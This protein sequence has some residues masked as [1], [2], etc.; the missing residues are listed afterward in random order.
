ML[1]FSKYVAAGND[2]VIMEDWSQ[3]LDLRSPQIVAL[4]DRRFG[5]GADG[6]LLLRPDPDADFRM[7][8]YNADGSRGEMCGNGARSL[9]HFARSRG[10]A[11]DQGRFQADDGFHQYS[12]GPE[13][14]RVEIIVTDALHDWDV[15]QTGC[16]FINTGVPHL[17][18]P[19]QGLQEFDL[20]SLGKQMNSHPAHPRGT[21]VNVVERLPQGLQVR[22]WER[23]VNTET[24]AC[25]TGAAAVSIFAHAKWE[26]PWPIE[27]D[28]KGGRLRVDHRGNQYWLGGPVGLVFTGRI[29]LS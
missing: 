27:L 21:N 10:K 8:Y 18:V 28:F 3:T 5:V 15:P 17:I 9:V 4:C 16:G 13:G 22:T 26:L 29:E 2:F 23:G 1:N 11:L 25:G 12:I 24:L 19:A 20:D 6:V 14:I 7:L